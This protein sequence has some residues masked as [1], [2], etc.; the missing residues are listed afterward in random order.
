MFTEVL[1]KHRGLALLFVVCLAI[2]LFTGCGEESSSATEGEEKEVETY[3]LSFSHHWPAKHSVET[4]IAQGWGKAVEEAT[5]GRVKI[6]TYPGETLMPANE[7]YEGVVQGVADVGLS[8][9]GYTRGRFPVIETFLL[10]A[11][12][13]KSAEALGLAANELIPEINPEEIQDVHHLFTFGSGPMDLMTKE[14]VREMEDLHGMSLGVPG[15]KGAQTLEALG[16]AP[17]SLPMSEWYEALQK[18]VMDGG[19]AAVFV[20]KGFKLGDVTADYITS[21]PFLPQN[22]FFCVM[23]KGTW[24][25]LPAD[26][27]KTITEVTQEFYAEKVPMLWDQENMAAMKA[28]REQKPAEYIVLPEDEQERWINKIEFIQ[29]E[30]I[31]ALEAKGIPGRDILKQ[32]K[33]TVDKYN[34]ECPDIDYSS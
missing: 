10:P 25:S 26:I 30:H 33:E 4:V 1:K 15:G 27:Q 34:E 2:T 11:I 9:Y 13:A 19:V 6:V 18:G 28:L 20:T 23:N 32:I 5:D 21:T 22:L 3:E 16:G 12:S 7:C 31:D 29:D 24:N 14:P 8:V 17:V